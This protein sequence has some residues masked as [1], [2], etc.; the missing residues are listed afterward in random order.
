M[1]D[2]VQP[3]GLLSFGTDRRRRY[4]RRCS[5]WDGTNQ[6]QGTTPDQRLPMV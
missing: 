3:Q 6:T 1:V 4:E 2:T 5:C